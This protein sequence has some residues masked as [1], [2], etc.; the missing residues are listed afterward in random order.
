MSFEIN[1]T[2]RVLC[3]ACNKSRPVEFSPLLP[4]EIWF[5][6]PT[7]G[8]LEQLPSRGGHGNRA[9]KRNVRK[10]GVIIRGRSAATL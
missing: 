10:G 3:V 9:K 7:H 2:A 5:R 6:C 8:P 1:L 4:P